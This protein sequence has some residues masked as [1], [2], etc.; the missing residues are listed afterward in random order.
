[1]GFGARLAEER[2]RLG[3]KQAQFAAL[4]GCDAPKQS[5]Y[6]NGHRELRA[7]YLARIAAA[8]VD[9]LYVLT[10]RRHEGEWLGED[11][12]AMIA[13]WLAL[14]PEMQPAILDFVK[15]F[16]RLFHR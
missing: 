11:G 12:N 4:V 7:D 5:L 13:A 14:P 8:G 15:D 1:M 3:Y 16:A 2:K 10:G 6:E 9:V